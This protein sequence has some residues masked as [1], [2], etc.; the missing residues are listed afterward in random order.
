MSTTA[1]PP[2]PNTVTTDQDSPKLDWAVTAD[3]VRIW[4]DETHIL[5]IEV[6]GKLHADVRPRRVFPISGKAPYVSLISE[7]ESEVA[8]ILNPEDLDHGSSDALDLA[9]GRTYH[10]ATITRV[11]EISEA[12]GVSMWRV[13]T[14]CGY[15]TFE[16]IDRRQHIRLLPGGRFIITDAD[17]NRFEIPCVYDLDQTSQ[18][19]VETET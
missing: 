1:M 13:M 6:D 2:T 7:K 8:L 10:R 12:M 17:G 16:V 11:D 18:R 5:N 15:A 9:L 14:D 4:R 3:R 19:L